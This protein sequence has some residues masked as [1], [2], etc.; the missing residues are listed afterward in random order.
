MSSNNC[1]G[2][3]CLTLGESN[4]TNEGANLA[5]VRINFFM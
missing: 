3:L 4:N 1:M 2:Q 5:R